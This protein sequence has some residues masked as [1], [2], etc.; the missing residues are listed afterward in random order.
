MSLTFLKLNRISLQFYLINNCIFFRMPDI[1]EIALLYDYFLHTF[2][3]THKHACV[4]MF[5]YGCVNTN[6]YRIYCSII[7]YTFLKCSRWCGIWFLDKYIIP[8][9]IVILDKDW[10]LWILIDIS[11]DR[12]YISHNGIIKLSNM[13]SCLFYF[14]VFFTQD[15]KMLRTFVWD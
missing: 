9:Q 15:M 7:E 12:V 13:N 5:V 10:N 1:I 4:C 2:T 6:N 8:L 11:V 3:P 14:Q